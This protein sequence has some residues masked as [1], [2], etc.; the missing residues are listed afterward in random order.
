MEFKTLNEE[1]LLD[2]EEDYQS[3]RSD[4]T[5]FFV[6]VAY[7]KYLELNNLITVVVEQFITMDRIIYRRI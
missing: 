4:V 1:M 7:P 3:N 5:L 6:R 2:N